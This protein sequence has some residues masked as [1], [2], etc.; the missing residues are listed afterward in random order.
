MFN[1]Q[2]TRDAYYIGCLYIK[3][4]DAPGNLTNQMLSVVQLLMVGI[5]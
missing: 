3:H 5:I 4:L 1:E 2:N